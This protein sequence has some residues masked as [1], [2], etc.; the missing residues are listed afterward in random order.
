MIIEFVVQLKKFSLIL[1]ISFF[2]GLGF[3]QRGYEL[4][5]RTGFSHYFGD[6][7][8]NYQLNDAGFSLGILGRRNLNERISF[9]AGF[10][11][12]R[13]SASDF[14]SNNNFQ[15]MRN[16]DF[17]S[18]IFD[19]NVVMEFNFF[20]YIHGSNENYYSPY[21]FGGLSFLKFNPT[22]EYNGESYSLRDLGTEGQQNGQEYALFS[23]A[24]VFGI[25]FKWDINRDWSLNASLSGRNV[26]SDYIDDVSSEYPD[27]LSLQARRGAIAVALSDR[28]PDPNFAR[29]GMQ[30]GNGKNN[31][32]IYFMQIGLMRYFG[33]LPCP[34]ISKS[35][36]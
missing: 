10:D 31:D 35:I 3:G 7:N 11:Y 17:K 36:Y 25:G 30:R 28:S 13:I 22:T 14:D 9:A 5:I 27:F 33:E 24:F 2:C 34:S 23:S 26:F 18:N 6:L 16:L 32:V 29:I 19:L 12:G 1:L 8:T 4:G 21:I 20:P 15:R